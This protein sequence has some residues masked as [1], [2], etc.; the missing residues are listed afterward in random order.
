MGNINNNAIVNKQ[1]EKSNNLDI[2]INLHNKYSTNKQGFNN[3]IASNYDI[4]P[5][6]KI[7]ELGCGTGILWK[8]NIE[9]L[10]ECEKVVFTDLSE[11]MLEV[12]KNNIGEK[13][14]FFFEKVDAQNLPYSDGEFDVIIANMM[15]YHIPD[16]DKALSEIK[17]VLKADGKFYSATFGENGVASEINK[18]LNVIDDTNY[19]F[20][21]QNGRI[22]LE[23]FF[24]NVVKLEYIDG[25]DIGDKKDLVDYILSFK[26]FNKWNKFSKNELLDIISKYE[27]DGKIYIKKEYGMFVSSRLEIK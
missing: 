2:R 17:R 1:Y 20:T 11:G 13:E 25:L 19:V 6:M 23:K 18:M 22:S 24:S 5:G 14:S 3:W 12:I 15:L 27:V 10:N 8:N 9:L 7:L 21:L 4:K 16:L 26:D